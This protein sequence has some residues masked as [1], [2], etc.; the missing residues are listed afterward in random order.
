MML[1]KALKWLGPGFLGG[2]L[3]GLLIAVPGIAA[4]RISAFLGP[5]QFSLSLDSLE[6]FAADGSIPPEFEF[7]ARRLTPTQ[8]TQLRQAL[9]YR[10]PF[11]PVAVSQVTYST[12]GEGALQW[13]GEVVQPSPQQNGSK[14]LRAALILAAAQPDGLTIANVLRHFPA[15]TVRVDLAKAFKLAQNI[16]MGTGDRAVLARVQQDA[17]REA[18]RISQDFSQLPDWRQPGAIPWQRQSLTVQDPVRQRTVAVDLYLPQVTTDAPIPLVVLL[19]GLAGDRHS[20]PYLAEHLASYGVAVAVPESPGNGSRRFQ[21][22]FQGTAP[23][24]DYLDIVEQ[25]RDVSVLLDELQRRSRTDSDLARLNLQQV[26]VMGHSQGGQAALLLAGASIDREYLRQWC[27]STTGLNL[28]QFTQ[29]RLLS[30]P[31]SVVE[32]L[33]D[34][35]VTAVLPISPPTIA[36]LSPASLQRIQIPVMLVAAGADTITPA[37]SEQIRPFTAL[38][39]RDRYLGLIENATHLSPLDGQS[40]NWLGV[41]IPP[42]LFGPTPAATRSYLK[43]LSTAFFQTYLTPRPIDPMFLTA[44]YGS[45]LSQPGLTLHLLKN[46]PGM[47]QESPERS[48]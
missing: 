25:P 20:F 40:L 19:H 33:K 26:G 13:L 15:H 27:Q 47:G 31:A 6:A 39:S 42:E 22:F 23:E 18:T 10:L 17:A 5:L 2:S 16:A 24:P 34:Q 29:C 9:V 1:K 11:A 7:F 28:A 43:A 37:V 46:W 14:A 45:H 30:Q 35:R 41:A 21:Q 12:V 4:E 3:A 32:N 48:P 38:A 36:L 44:A 8:R